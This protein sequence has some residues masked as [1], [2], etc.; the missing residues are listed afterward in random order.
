MH[1]TACGILD[2]GKADPRIAYTARPGTRDDTQLYVA[3]EDG[4]HRRKLTDTPGDKG[5]PSWSPN[6][7]RI[8]FSWE[9]ESQ[10]FVYLVNVDGMGGT[11]LTPGVSTALVGYD[12][13]TWS[14]SGNEVAFGWVGGGPIWII[15]ADG[16]GQRQVTPSNLFSDDPAWSPDGTKLAFWARTDGGMTDLDHL[17][18][19]LI[20]P[21]GS[22]LRN[23]TNS[24]G[25]H[26][27][28]P[29]WCP[30]GTR[31]AF[32]GRTTA[33]GPNIH[34]MDADGRNLRQLTHLTT[35]ITTD[36]PDWSPDGARIIFS[37]A[38]GLWVVN[39]DGTGPPKR[40]IGD[41]LATYPDW[42]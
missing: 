3:N 41:R 27:S 24:P 29:A 25:F 7:T 10:V 33:G 18:I 31:I 12:A 37:T 23:L 32:V 34:V 15:G 38:D 8:A 30:A 11:R 2:G 4:S 5:E 9:T 13:P 26:E 14:P 21:D 1:V 39:A 19:Y 16:S 22:G 36:S 42:R 6:G 17:D 35:A 40:L 20:N 28:S